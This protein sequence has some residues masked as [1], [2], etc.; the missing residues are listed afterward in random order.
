MATFLRVIFVGEPLYINA[1]F[2]EHVDIQDGVAFIFTSHFLK[3][4]EKGTGLEEAD[5]PHMNA[6]LW[7]AYIEE[8][9]KTKGVQS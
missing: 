2:I 5:A 8:S 4:V 3:E 9:Q 1:D 7:L 6:N